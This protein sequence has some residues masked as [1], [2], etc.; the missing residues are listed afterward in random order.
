MN[1]LM[2]P[3]LPAASRPSKRI[4]TP[5]AGLLGPGLELQQLDLEVVLLRLVGLAATSGCGTG[6]RPLRQWSTS[7]SSES[8]GIVAVDRLVLAR[9]ARRATV[10]RS[11][12]DGA[13]Q[14]LVEPAGHLDH[15]GAV[16]PGEHVVDRLD[17]GVLGALDAVG[18]HEALDPGGAQVG[19]DVAVGG[20]AGSGRASS[21]RV[22]L[23]SRARSAG[24][25]PVRRPSLLADRT[26]R[27]RPRD[28][29]G[30]RPA[31]RASL[32]GSSGACPAGS[33][34]LH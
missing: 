8:M 6:R 20:R 12:G 25:V 28:R 31:G 18:H 27:D 34:A 9:A 26:G 24:R 30:L 11:S 4:T 17:P 22:R 2:V 16:G 10:G 21:S 7:S 32:R 15:L 19:G 1:R 14:H 3:P 13:G 5:L 33:N 29:C 23:V